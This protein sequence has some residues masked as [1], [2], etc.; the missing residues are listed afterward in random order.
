MHRSPSQRPTRA[1]SVSTTA[2][3]A[4]PIL[5][6]VLAGVV[7][8]VMLR[9]SKTELQTSGDAAALAAGRALAD[10][11]FLVGDPE[12]IRA[13][14]GR[15]RDAAV[16]YAQANPVR[17]ETI[18]LDRNLRHRPD[19]DIVFGHLDQPINGNFQRLDPSEP[20][21]IRR[22]NAVRISAHRSA[23]GET[24]SIRAT[25]F[26][27]SAVV[28]LKPQFDKPLPLVPVALY[29]CP[30]AD[31]PSPERSWE[32]QPRTD[33]FRYDAGAGRWV[34]GSDGVPEVTV[35]LGR[36]EPDERS[37]HGIALRLGTH[38][39]GGFFTQ[40][41]EG[42]AP[43]ELAEFGGQLLLD[44]RRRLAVPPASFPAHR[45]EESDPFARMARAFRELAADPEPRLWPMFGDLRSDDERVIL[46]GFAAVRI[47]RQDEEE[48][49][50]RLV[51]QPTIFPTPAAVTD[52]GRPPP[53][54]SWGAT[55]CRLRLAE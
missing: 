34:S 47:V 50:V 12:A 4:L 49:R 10:D 8:L 25:A 54:C 19:G 35:V 14:L 32:H 13:A 38:T 41:Q 43:A 17:G 7:S 44:A 52:A 28:G 15:A 2:L 53:D 36:S 21:D 40:V 27:D 23:S 31:G 29:S 5:I 26:L 55:A 48:G 51:L 18:A 20:G 9:G 33:Q 1:G 45:L 11:A 37:V 3:I 39:L 24:L 42:V 46:T 16:E 6:L 22:V 30:S